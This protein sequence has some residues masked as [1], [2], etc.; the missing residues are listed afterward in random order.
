[1]VNSLHYGYAGKFL[2]V[3]LDKKSVKTVPVKKRLAAEYLGGNGFCSKILYD[4]L[5]PSLNNALSRKNVLT[6]MTGPLTGTLWPQGCRYTVAALSPITRIWGEAHSA[7]FWGPE[8]KFAGFDGIIIKGA[9]KKPVYLWIEDNVAEIRDAS[10]L[11]GLKVSETDSLI[12]KDSKDPQTKVTC[13]GPASENLVLSGCIMN[14]LDRAAARSGLGAVMGSKKLK[15]ISV[16]GHGS[17]RIAKPAGYLKFIRGLHKRILA[18]PFTEGRVKYGTTSLIELMNHIGR[19][20]T[21]NFQRGDFAEFE[22]ISGERVRKRNLIKPRADFACVQR[23][24]RYTRVKGHGPYAC[25]GGGPEFETL[26]AFGS[27]CGNSDLDS[28]LY[29]NWLCNELGMDTIEAGAAIGWAMECFEKGLITKKDTGGLDL[30]WGNAKVIVKL[31]EDMAYGRGFGKVLSQGAFWAAETLGVGKEFVMH[32]KRASIAGQEVRAQKSMGLA[33]AVAARGADHLYAFPVLDEVGFDDAI[34][35]RYGAKYLPEIGD[36]LN[37]KYKGLMVFDNENF[38]MIVEAVG[39][40]K[41]G[42]MVPPV[43]FYPEIAQGIKITCGMKFSVKQLERVGERI[44]NL[45]RA[46]NMLRGVCKSDDSL[47]KRML[48]VPSPSPAA[49]GHV[50]ELDVML[51]DYYKL[52]GWDLKTGI[53][54]SSRLKRLGLSKIDR[55]LQKLRRKS[56]K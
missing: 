6:F 56:G 22:K 40:C 7:G 20:P 33:S 55:D 35:E 45:N 19:L 52:R 2:S 49:Q 41:Y 28:V 12:K 26:S 47:P 10:H 48:E 39:A 23:C 8:L 37:P 14:D 31:T 50:V 16:R 53:P 44:V 1:M 27:R 51:A 36:R 32:V 24:G 18:H 42:T 34:K 29:A 30:S 25:I 9:S 4:M 3:D 46:F 17:V 43:L 5:N 21:R 54:K 13:I 11:W 15:A 38:S